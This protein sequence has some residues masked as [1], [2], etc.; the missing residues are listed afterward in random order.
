VHTMHPTLLIGPADW[1]PARLP[2]AEFSARLDALWQADPSADGVI[3]YGEPAHHGELAW[4]THVTPKLEACVALIAR[5]GDA[6]LLV[7]GGVNMLPAA[8]P[9]TWIENLLP[10]RG[11]GKVIAD[12]ARSVGA[13]RLV[14]LNGDAMPEPLHRAAFGVESAECADA[15]PLV[16]GL[17]RPKSAR[18]LALVREACATLKASVAALEQAQRAGAG[19][20]A[21][22]LTAEEAAWNRGAQDVRTLFSLDGGRTLEPFGTPIAAARDPL[23]AYL[24][25]RHSG[26]WA[27]G[28]VV[29]STKA[30]RRVDGARRA[31]QAGLGGAS[32]GIRRG[33]LARLLTAGAPHV[34]AGAVSLGLTL[35][36]A[37]DPTDMLLSGEVL[38]LRAGDADSGAIVSAMVALTDE[39]HE[40][41]WSQD[42]Q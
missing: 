5:S 4:L 13:R 20:T 42:I 29:A 26:Y 7:G 32:A 15:T 17:M 12:W 6:R 3:V 18:E 19:V 2:R 21:A 37:D 16:R 10:L 9:L 30:V 33:D 31:L 23:H 39:G 14:V 40:I 8:A 35:D 24:A 11:A 28:F 25:V 38:S 27:E 22:I 1:D 34:M 36:E 41:L